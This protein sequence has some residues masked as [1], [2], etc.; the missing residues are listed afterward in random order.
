[1]KNKS[2]F[3]L[4]EMVFVIVIAGVIG[5]F[6]VEFFLNSYQNFIFTSV[7]H[8]L[9]QNSQSAVEF[10]ASRAQ[11]RIKNSTIARKAD[12]TF[13]GINNPDGTDYTILEWIGSD[14]EGFLGNSA[15]TPNLPNWSGVIDLN[16][17]DA[18]KIVSPM[19]STTAINDLID[20]LSNGDSSIADA[21][22]YFIGSNQDINGY[23][24]NSEITDQNQVMHPITAGANENEFVSSTGVIDFS[25]VDVY[26]FY[27]LAWSAYAVVLDGTDLKFYY[28]YQPWKGESYTSEKAKSYLIM[29]N[30][31]TFKFVA[32]DNII[33]IQV[34][35]QSDVISNEEYSICKEK[36]VL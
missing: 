4:L 21:A 28:G 33:K 5:K 20:T 11:Y 27:T 6:G 32:I 22:L 29:E 8:T 26:E 19:S 16:L 2:A 12:G 15:A 14:V 17:G 3:T 31:S 24:W 18:T 25:G 30:V 7:N 13:E 9:E 36:T 1:M 23:G 34:C 10:I 35:V